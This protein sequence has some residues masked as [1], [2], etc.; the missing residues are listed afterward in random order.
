M[1]C[2]ITDSVT[3]GKEIT[4]NQRLKAGEPGK[5][6]LRKWHEIAF[7]RWW[8]IH[9]AKNIRLSVS[10]VKEVVWEK[11]GG[12][13][14]HGAW[15]EMKAGWWGWKAEWRRQLARKDA[16]ELNEGQSMWSYTGGV[17]GMLKHW[18]TSN[19]Q[20]VLIVPICF[21]INNK[22]IFCIR[23]LCRFNNI[24]FSSFRK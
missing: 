16:D 24:E 1:T 6:S 21:I 23:N 8:D 10:W 9:Q 22:I 17:T 19:W 15:R 2:C 12:L 14:Q 13:K 3:S 4:I 11:Q 5:Y 20:E 7:E 18:N